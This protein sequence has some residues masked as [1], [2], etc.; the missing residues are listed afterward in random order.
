MKRKKIGKNCKQNNKIIIRN[1]IGR[2]NIK[3][4]YYILYFCQQTKHPFF[5]S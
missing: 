5:N 3:K 2:K 4:T 1:K